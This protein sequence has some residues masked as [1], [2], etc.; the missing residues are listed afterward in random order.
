MTSNLMKNL[1][2]SFLL[3]HATFSMH[4]NSYL[5]LTRFYHDFTLSFCTPIKGRP[6]PMV[7]FLVTL[8]FAAT[9]L[10]IAANAQ[11]TTIEPVHVPAGTI[12]T[13]HLQTRLRAGN[14]VTD[15]LP[16][17]TTLEVK[18]LDSMDSDM[19]RDGAEFHG[20]V[21]SAVLAGDEVIVHPDAEVHGLLALLR[22]KSHPDG[23]RY[24][25]LITGLT[26]HGKAMSLTA[27]LKTSFADEAPKTVPAP[28]VI[29]DT[30]RPAIVGPLPTHR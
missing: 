21:V 15:S 17:G 23:F 1:T 18:M 16:K 24:E 29:K 27:S 26:D 5:R 14:D 3:F 4:C 9:F 6:Q 12:L 22:S 20:S 10:P 19:D 8:V 2:K 13:F 25:L 28:A 30:A 11:K 7:R